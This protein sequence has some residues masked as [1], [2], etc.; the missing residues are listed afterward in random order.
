MDPTCAPSKSGESWLTICWANPA[1]SASAASPWAR[2]TAS[3]S[4]DAAGSTTDFSP[5]MLAWT[6]WPRRTGSTRGR[7]RGGSRLVNPWTFN[8]ASRT[9][10]ISRS[11]GASAPTSSDEGPPRFGSSRSVMRAIV[12]GCPGYAVRGSGF[13]PSLEWSHARPTADP[14]HARADRRRRSGGVRGRSDCRRH[15][16]VPR[17]GPRPLRRGGGHWS[18]LRGVGGT[19]GQTPGGDR[20]GD[21]REVA[22]QQGR[23]PAPNRRPGDRRGLRRCRVLRPPSRRSLRR[24]PVRHRAAEG[25]RAHLEEGAPRRGR[26]PLGDG[27]L[28]G[29]EIAIDLG[30]A[31][32]LVYRQ[33]EG[34]VF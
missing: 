18:H 28:V 29:R 11:K 33:G 34:I 22:G 16:S 25:R 30:T 6:H 32:T 9:R 8:S 1:V 24:L 17:Y 3:A 26:V 13:G 21:A 12:G 14:D 10:W 19:G 2:P 20:R 5:S 23:A 31:N 15:L 4:F 7:S 27:E